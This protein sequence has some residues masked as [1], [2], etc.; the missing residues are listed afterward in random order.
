MGKLETLLL[1]HLLDFQR[2]DAQLVQYGFYAVGQ[3]SQ[4]LA[5]NQHARLLQDFRQALQGLL[6]PEERVALVEIVVVESQE[7]ILLLAS[8]HVEH[9][10]VDDADARMIH[11]GFV[12]VFHEEHV[13][14]ESHQSVAN[15]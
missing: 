7:G 12:G 4:V 9:G 3:H 10:F 5:T 6:T 2:E 1:G 14:N 8:Q 13:A 15:P 11:I